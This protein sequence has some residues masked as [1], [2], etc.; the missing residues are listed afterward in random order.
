MR[1]RR[2]MPAVAV[3]LLLAA[4]PSGCGD[5]GRSSRPTG[6][7]AVEAVVAEADRALDGVLRDLA[8]TLRLGGAQGSRSFAVCGDTGAPR[9]VVSNVFVHFTSASELTHQEA[10]TAAAE[11][12]AADGWAVVDPHN[13]ALL[14]ATRSRLTLHLRIGPSLVQVDLGSECVETSAA[15]AG[16]Y[17]DRPV[18]ELGRSSRARPDS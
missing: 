10:T 15:L 2:R 1:P 13:Q 12:L 16:A 5:P 11:L 9:G 4:A 6:A 8:R 3:L 18:A 14:T 7:R 17:D